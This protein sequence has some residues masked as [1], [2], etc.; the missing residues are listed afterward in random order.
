ME[1]QAIIFDKIPNTTSD[2]SKNILQIFP[3]SEK[4]SH[5]M[6]WVELPIKKTT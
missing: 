2:F 1:I 5:N 6:Y 4:H 3:N